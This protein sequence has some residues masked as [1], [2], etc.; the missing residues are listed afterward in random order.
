MVYSTCSLNP[1]EDEAVIASLLEKSEGA[2]ELADV[3]SELPGL[4]WMPGITHW[5]VIFLGGLWLLR[6]GTTCPACQS[7]E[8]FKLKQPHKYYFWLC[9][10]ICFRVNFQILLNDKWYSSTNIFFWQ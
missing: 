4:K 2:L 1:I 6:A 8:R 10:Q 5:K 7:R 9:S 3:S